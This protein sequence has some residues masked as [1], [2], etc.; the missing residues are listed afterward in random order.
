MATLC[1]QPDTRFPEKAHS[2]SSQPA[3]H[4]GVGRNWRQLFRD[5]TTSGGIRRHRQASISTGDHTFSTEQPRIPV[6][7]VDRAKT[8]Y[9]EQLGFV[10]DVDVQPTAGVRVVQLTTSR[11]GLSQLLS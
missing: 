4:A 5:S 9:V 6:A 10:E 8:F 1:A 7:D 2:S 11:Y 3:R